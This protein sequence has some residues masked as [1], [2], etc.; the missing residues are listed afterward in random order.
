VR[1]YIDSLDGDIDVRPYHRYV[2]SV[3]AFGPYGALARLE[4][5]LESGVSRGLQR[6]DDH[7]GRRNLR[8]MIGMDGAEL[9]LDC[10]IFLLRQRGAL[11][12][13]TS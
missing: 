12:L 5:I 3:R 8:H 10:F 2:G 9:H 1:P 7:N 4:S 6:L 11:A 13:R